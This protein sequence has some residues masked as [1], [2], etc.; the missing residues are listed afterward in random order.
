MR[1][2][3]LMRSF[4]PRAVCRCRR[5]VAT[6][7]VST[8]PAASDTRYTRPTRRSRRSSPIR[9]CTRCSRACRCRCG[10]ARRRRQT[11]AGA[12]GC[13]KR[14]AASSSRI[15]ATADRPC[16][17]SR[18][19]PCAHAFHSPARVVQTHAAADDRAAQPADVVQPPLQPPLQPVLVQWTSHSEDA[20][21]ELLK[22][23]TGKQ[24]EAALV[25]TRVRQHLPDR[26]ADWLMRDAGV[27][28][29]QPVA[30]LTRDVRRR[31]VERLCRYELPW[32][33]DEGYRKAEVTGGGVAL[34]EV[35]PKTLESRRHRASS[36]AAKCSM[37][38]APSAATTSRGPG[39]PAA[40]RAAALRCPWR[41]PAQP[42][43]RRPAPS[44]HRT[45]R[46]RHDG[47]LRIQLPA[48]T[49]LD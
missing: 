19:S 26:L 35:R 2:S 27:T 5:P 9:R 22:P 28:P 34:D 42:P 1:R 11:A 10:C 47:R 21:H 16:S 48:E 4:S 39:P 15:A 23:A 8:S 44:R 46:P 29:D 45:R 41:R 13:S 36:C 49:D 7:P 43:S 24:A 25:R 37:R 32:T 12:G 31:L 40:W 17:T 20:W 18:T 3:R 30:T 14:P 6:G 38:S 33:S